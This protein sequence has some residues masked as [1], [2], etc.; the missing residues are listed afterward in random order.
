MAELRRVDPRR[1]KLW[2]LS[3]PVL[4]YIAVVETAATLVV[5]ATARL[6]PADALAWTWF[7]LLAAGAVVH[8]EA[9]RG[10]E[11]IREIAAEGSPHAHM[12]SVWLFA[13]VLL[14]PM[15]LLVALIGISYVHAWFRVY[16][17]RALPHRKLFSACTVI[18][19]C[20]A[21]KSVLLAISPV[22]LEGPAG[23]LGVTLA[24]FVYW[25]V[26]YALVV[27]A[28][29]MTNLDKP[30]RSAFGHP[31]D[32]LIIAASIG[33]GCGLAIIMT[34]HPWLT[35][36][37]LVTVLALHMGLLLPQFRMAARTDSKT[38][39]VDATF[40]HEMAER[41]LDRS[42]RLGSTVGVLILDLDHFKQINDTYGHLAGDRVLRV[43]ADTIK[44]VVRAYDLVG[45]FGGEEFAV[46]LPGVGVNGVRATAERIRFE[47]GALSVG[48]VDRSGMDRT[49][50]NFTASIGA[51]IFPDTATE[52]SPLLLA[53]D[54]ALYQAK[55]E[56]RDRT[57][58]AV[59]N[60]R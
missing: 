10:I 42:R 30:R 34:S 27:G 53:A 54:E 20:A 7:A 32:Q 25:I 47:I 51:A 40:W 41:E 15:P 13:G 36:L 21:G 12:Q 48:V 44:S 46:L 55:G 22:S 19:G 6:T 57:R 28:I 8:L 24:G 33:L 11:R 4:T 16:R 18:L 31:S 59:L 26:N 2:S 3:L 1:W 45:R 5:V 29:I 38:G 39:L 17:R 58:V 23:L 56:G 9:A 49:I 37:L 50:T 60:L 52:L 43:V 14:L 35:P